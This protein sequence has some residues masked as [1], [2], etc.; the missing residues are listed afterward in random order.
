M[1]SLIPWRTGWRVVLEVVQVTHP[2]AANKGCLGDLGVGMTSARTRER[3]RRRL[4]N[5]GIRN[6]EVLAIMGRLP[7]H[8]F[9]DE[10][11]SSHAYED[12]ALPIGHG[13]TLSQPYT[14]ARMTEALLEPGLP[15]SILEIG[16][17]DGGVGIAGTAGL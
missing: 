11:L 9:L 14:V 8:R 6:A 12:S 5:A 2:H 13:Q 4:E 10:A 15:E 1:P 7:R 3:L 17:P 16:I